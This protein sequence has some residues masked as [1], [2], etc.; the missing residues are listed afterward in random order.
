M[1]AVLSLLAVVAAVIGSLIY[2]GNQSR[3]DGENSVK[4]KQFE[5]ALDEIRK[6]NSARNSVKPDGVQSDPDNLDRKL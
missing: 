3:R 5:G 4:L 1:T 2:L 6:A